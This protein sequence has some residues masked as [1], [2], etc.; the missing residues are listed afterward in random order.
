MFTAIT[1]H[2]RVLQLTLRTSFAFFSPYT[3]LQEEAC[4]LRAD[5]SCTSPP[6]CPNN[7][8]P[9]ERGKRGLRFEASLSPLDYS[10]DV[11]SLSAAPRRQRVNLLMA[12]G[13]QR[14]NAH[15]E[16]N[17]RQHS[18][19]RPSQGKIT[20]CTTHAR[21]VMNSAF[22]SSFHQ[23]VPVDPSH[24]T[25]FVNCQ[26]AQPQPTSQVVVTVAKMG[27]TFTTLP[28][29]TSRLQ[30]HHFRFEGEFSLG[31]FPEHFKAKRTAGMLMC[32]F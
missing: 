30:A 21:P 23:L 1:A 18:Y 25:R 8:V 20:T 9:I 12:A 16:A 6:R 24:V 11:L 3:A 4:G 22:K 26:R 17:L 27:K 29:S 2:F 28:E 32:R 5:S 19:H 15:P 13:S 7:G 14:H 10:S 31:C